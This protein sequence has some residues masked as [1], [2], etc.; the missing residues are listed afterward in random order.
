MIGYTLRT[1]SRND[2]SNTP[3]DNDD[4]YILSALAIRSSNEIMVIMENSIKEISTK[5]G[6][7]RPVNN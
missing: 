3:I 6:P 4:D 1:S 2:I 5:G 7:R